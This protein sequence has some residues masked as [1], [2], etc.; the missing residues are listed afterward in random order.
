MERVVSADALFLETEDLS[1][2]RVW[3]RAEDG[4]GEAGGNDRGELPDR[5]AEWPV[6]RGIVMLR[7]RLSA[8]LLRA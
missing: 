5:R 1:V 7:R 8:A 4:T 2:S 6:Q 3:L